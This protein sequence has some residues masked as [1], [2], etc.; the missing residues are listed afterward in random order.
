MT[1][2]WDLDRYRAELGAGDNKSG[3]AASV[4]PVLAGRDVAVAKTLDG[5]VRRRDQ[6]LKL[7]E[8][9]LEEDFEGV[10]LEYR[11]HP[12]R[13][14]RFDLAIL[15]AMVALEVDGGGWVGGKHHRPAGRRIDNEKS[16]EA[17]RLGWLVLRVDCEHVRTGEA[18]A[19]LVEFARERINSVKLDTEGGKG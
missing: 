13:R 14:W 2:K 4:A 3:A 17:Q 19:L 1:E 10:R 5:Q 7:L 16:R 15:S 6:F 11:F 8:G 18:L 9:L 12:V